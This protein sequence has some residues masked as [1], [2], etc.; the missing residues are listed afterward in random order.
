MHCTVKKLA[1]LHNTLFVI[2]TLY[3][4]ETSYILRIL[5]L[6]LNLLFLTLDGIVSRTDATLSSSRGTL[7]LLSLVP[8]TASS[9]TFPSFFITGFF[10]SS[11]SCFPFFLSPSRIA[12]SSFS[13]FTSMYAK[14]AVRSYR[15]LYKEK[16]RHIMITLIIKCHHFI[17]SEIWP[18]MTSNSMTIPWTFSI[19]IPPKRTKIFE[20]P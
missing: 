5:L 1:I 2:L 9:S 12:L 17:P 3:I 14:N 8:A 10:F 19:E 16:I 6:I 20:P 4:H 13:H 15:K 11:S 18:K 7:G